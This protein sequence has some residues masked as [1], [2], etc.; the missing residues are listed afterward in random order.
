[1]RESIAYVIKNV[2]RVIRFP[3]PSTRACSKLLI[4]SFLDLLYSIFDI[5]I[6]F[7]DLAYELLRLLT[8]M[9]REDT[10]QFPGLLD[11]FKKKHSTY[12]HGK[13]DIHHINVK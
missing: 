4:G 1:M 13:Y 8:H 3:I 6:S 7:G 5:L 2:P 12:F 9:E 11:C 10:H